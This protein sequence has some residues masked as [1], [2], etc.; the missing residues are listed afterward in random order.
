MIVKGNIKWERSRGTSKED[1]EVV[2]V[3]MS[4]KMKIH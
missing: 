3:Y 4:V 2:W 1:R